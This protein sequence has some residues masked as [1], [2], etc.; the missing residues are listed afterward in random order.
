[1]RREVPGI[2]SYRG[3]EITPLDLTNIKEIIEDFKKENVQA[4]AVCMLGSYAN[5]IHEDL[6]YA[7]IHELWPEVSIICSSMITRE[8]REYERTNTI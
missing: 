1:L 4:I 2:I 3:C 8:H 6:I 7:K 5:P